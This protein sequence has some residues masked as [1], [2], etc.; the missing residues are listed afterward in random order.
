MINPINNYQSN[1]PAMQSL[2]FPKGMSKKTTSSVKNNISNFL[3]KTKNEFKNLDN[4]SKMLLYKTIILASGLTVF[5]AYVASIVKAI[6][7]K[8]NELF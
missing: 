4:E 1:G 5:I 3:E 8:F 2:K 7:D 6:I